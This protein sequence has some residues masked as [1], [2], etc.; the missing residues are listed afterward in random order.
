M[1]N[2]PLYQRAEELVG[3][4]D[5]LPTIPTV[6][7][8]VLALLDQDDV[9]PEEVA[10]LML[11]DQTM[12]ARVLKIINSPAF[13]PAQPI[14]SLKSAVVY[15]GLSHVR[16]IVLTT[17]L[18]EVFEEDGPGELTTFWGHSFGVGMVAKIIAEKAGYRDVDQA[19]IAGV[20]HDIG[21]V[22]LNSHQREGVKRVRERVRDDATTLLEAETAEFGTTHCEVGLC[23]ARRW[24]FPEAY[25]EAVALHHAPAQATVDPVLCSLVN[26]ADLFWSIHQPDY[27]G[28]FSFNLASEPG[29]AILKERLAGL[30]GLDEERFRYELE[31]AVTQVQELVESIFGA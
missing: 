16:E 10:E 2:L 27:G 7:T 23:L 5:R 1:E 9:N 13:R 15:L 29:W 31:D 21:V 18:L 3:N 24:N 30:K 6:A 14:T 19:Y 25:C 8:R 28:W 4:V 22:F 20:V 11:T 26:L 12:A 17:S